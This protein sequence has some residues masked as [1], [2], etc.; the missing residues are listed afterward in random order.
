MLAEAGVSIR[1]VRPVVAGLRQAGVDAGPILARVGIDPTVLTDPDAR[2]AHQTVLAL[3][4]EA[5]EA[6]GD[7]DFGLHTAEGLDLSILDV[8]GYAAMSSATLGEGLERAS[9]LHRLNHD[10]ARVGLFIEEQGAVWRHELPNGAPLPRHPAEFV[11]TLALVAARQMTGVAIKPL[12]AL[13]CHSEPASTAEHRR[14]F[15]SKVLFSQEQ[16]AMILPREALFIPCKKA[17]P[18]LLLVLERHA[19]DLVNRL[20]KTNSLV[21]RVQ[22]LLTAELHGGDPSAENIASK[23][24]MSVRTLARRLQERGTSHKLLLDALRKELCER[25]LE[26]PQLGIVEVTFLLGFSDTSSFHRAF[27]RWHNQTPSEYRKRVS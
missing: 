17:D 4:R 5:V 27:K 25:Y 1:L 8:Q 18:G 20:P 6:T 19:Q 10:A 15:Q 9:R 12:V 14:I 16:T 21:D 11:I 3:W 23:L 22:A 24:K 26:D 7:D 2:V 13:F